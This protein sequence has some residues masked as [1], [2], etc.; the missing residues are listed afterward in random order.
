MQIQALSMFPT[1]PA[2]Q[3]PSMADFSPI[4]AVTQSVTTASTT[5]GQNFPMYKRLSNLFLFLSALLSTP[6]LTTALGY[7]IK[8]RDTIKKTRWKRHFN[9]VIVIALF[10]F[11]ACFEESCFYFCRRWVTRWKLICP[12]RQALCQVNVY[13]DLSIL[14]HLL[15]CI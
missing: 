14:D 15:I 4:F 7:M 13:M 6:V 9:V 3:H 10:G 1:H 12:C 11:T 8:Y 5:R 2:I